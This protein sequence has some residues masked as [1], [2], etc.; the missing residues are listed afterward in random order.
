MAEQG[1]ISTHLVSI[2]RRAL[3]Q[4]LSEDP[5]FSENHK[6]YMDELQNLKSFCMVND[7][8][9]IIKEELKAASELKLLNESVIMKYQ[10]ENIKLKEEN[11]ELKKNIE[12]VSEQLRCGLEEKITI[13]KQ[14]IS[15]LE[16]EV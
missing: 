11:K 14:F 16:K 4:R 8:I 1:I 6:K 13:A 7:Q 2:C 3:D 15:F 12:K 10:Q 5:S 9:R